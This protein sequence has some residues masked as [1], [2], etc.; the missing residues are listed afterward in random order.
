MASDA[1]THD[2]LIVGG[3]PAGLSAG[4]YAARAGL[5]T[6]LVEMGAPG[7]QI[8]VSSVL[9]NY[10]GI[11]SITGI[12]FGDMLLRHAEGAGCAVIRD[13]VT[14]IDALEDGTFCTMVGG[15][16]Q[17]S[18]TVVYAAGARPRLA[19]F[20]G[21]ERFTGRG[22]SYCATCDGM[23]FRNKPV[24]VVGSGAAACEEAEFLAR[25]AS[26][27]TMVVRGTELKAIVS[28]RD[29]IMQNPKIDVRFSTKIVRLEGDRM[30]EQITLE[31]SNTGEIETVEYRPGGF[32][33]FVFVGYEPRIALVENLVEVHNAAVATDG[34]MATKTPGLFAAGDVRDTVLRQAVTAV[35]DGAVAAMSASRYL[36][37]LL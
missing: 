17:T 24:Y 9:E 12:E 20:E 8:S 5:N 10:P 16:P 35:S 23:I 18:R 14:K 30:P 31:D 26:H 27:V 28:L 36:D 37:G 4:I 15:E 7:G 13:E 32:G 33:V 25:V 22:V 19:G 21:E 6:V 11:S 3:G 1:T 29:S 2:V 34:N